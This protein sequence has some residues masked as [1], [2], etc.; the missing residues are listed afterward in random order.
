[1]NALSGVLLCLHRQPGHRWLISNKDV[2]IKMSQVLFSSPHDV[3]SWI[4]RLNVSW[5]AGS[6]QKVPAASV[7]RFGVGRKATPA[8][9]HAAHYARTGSARCSAALDE[10][11][12]HVPLH[13]VG[14]VAGSGTMP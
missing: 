7:G 12:Q 9:R 3:T 6:G 1:M 5:V 4:S 13:S 2:Q 8:A 14:M 10:T 11:R